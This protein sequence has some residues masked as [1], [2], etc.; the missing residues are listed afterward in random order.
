ME[1]KGKNL[2]WHK[3][4]IDVL[5]RWKANGHKSCVIWFTGLSASGKSTLANALSE[6]LH[7]MNVKNYLLDGDNVRHGLNKDL[8]FSAGDR[9]ENIRRIAE[10]SRLFVDAGLI[11][12]TAF[13][14]PFKADRENARKTMRPDDFIEVFLKCP[15]SE[16]EKRDPKGIYKKA[17]C[18]DIKEFTGISSPYEEP[19]KPEITIET[20][21]LS[22]GECLNTLV[23]YLVTNG[24]V[25]MKQKRV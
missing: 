22:P 15:I 21:K 24:Y 19:D 20:G 23:S 3:P 17:K 2:Y 11:V 9:H 13:I 14:S 10:V 6:V 8:G 1:E 5:E 25:L 7:G 12:L 18:G 16:C 4:S